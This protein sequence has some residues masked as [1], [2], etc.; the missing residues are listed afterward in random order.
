MEKNKKIALAVIVLA[1]IAVA[2]YFLFFQA[3]SFE[4]E[5]KRMA[6]SWIGN[7][8]TEE[9]LH[10]STS[11]FSLDST[12][13]G[14]VKADLLQFK[15]STK[16]LAAAELADAYVSFAQSAIALSELKK[17]KSEIQAIIG[18]SQKDVCEA[19][20]LIDTGNTRLAQLKDSTAGYVSKISAFKEKYPAESKAV[21]IE[22]VFSI[23][24]EEYGDL[25]SM[26]SLAAIFRGECK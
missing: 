21:A 5:Y 6:L 1:A 22:N 12:A 11:L 2:G 16:N 26:L 24:A 9:Q 23:N 8:V 18:S 3:P 17:T 25:E 20:P 4:Q 7:G 15:S 10:G 13:L 14:K 19:L